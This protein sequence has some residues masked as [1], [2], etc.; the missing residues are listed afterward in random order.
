M[1]FLLARQLEMLNPSAS[2]A[3][4][5]MSLAEDPFTI[6]TNCK[7]CC[8]ASQKVYCYLMA[9]AFNIQHIWQVENS[10]KASFSKYFLS[11]NII[12]LEFQHA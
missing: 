12:I 2:K 6:Q 4:L 3:G 5:V 7:L 11:I 10:T 9:L 8:S 1:D